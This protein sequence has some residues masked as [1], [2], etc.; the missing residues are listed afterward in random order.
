MHPRGATTT[1]S[2]GE[3]DFRLILASTS[4][5]RGELLKR[6][7]VPFEQIPPVCDE[8]PEP[9]EPPA[10]LVQRLAQMK[11]HSVLEQLRKSASGASVSTVIIGSDQVADCD[12]EILG[13]PVSA[14]TAERQ[15]KTMSGKTV[16]FRTAMCVTGT[17]GPPESIESINV[18][19][20]FRELTAA[21]ISR[22]VEH[23]KP[24][25]CAG[26]FR[27]EGQGI[28]LLES[29]AGDDPNALIGLPLIR[30]AARLRERGI[31]VP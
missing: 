18:T 2:T 24:L 20:R 25:D 8:T 9:D 28:S 13:K 17:D 5:Y 19:A 7:D 29:L 12:G 3:R 10:R 6:L 11:A 23:D 14:D 21:E 30:L 1:M 4:R 26:S 15:L 31:A 22:Y 27:S 16:I